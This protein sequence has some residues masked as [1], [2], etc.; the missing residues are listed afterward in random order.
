MSYSDTDSLN[1]TITDREGKPVDLNVHPALDEQREVNSK[2]AMRRQRTYE[3]ILPR[4][5]AKALGVEDDLGGIDL[6]LDDSAT[7]RRHF[8]AQL[9]AGAFKPV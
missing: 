4:P 8:E 2:L 3:E 1:D 6:E 7:P 9:R 5:N